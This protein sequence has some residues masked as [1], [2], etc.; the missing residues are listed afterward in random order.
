MGGERHV[1]D[2]LSARE[3][4]GRL[5]PGFL[6]GSGEQVGPLLQRL[7][8]ERVH[9]EVGLRQGTFEEGRIDGEVG[10]RLAHAEKERELQPRDD[11]G[12]FAEVHA[13]LRLQRRHLRP[14][15][16][17]LGDRARFQAALVESTGALG[18][19]RKLAGQ[20]ELRLL[21]RRI[22][23]G[24]AHLQREGAERVVARTP[25][26]THRGPGNVGAQPGQCHRPR[27]RRATG[28]GA[29]VVVERPSYRGAELRIGDRGG[30][31]R[32]AFGGGD[33]RVS[34][35]QVE[36]A[37]A[38]DPQRVIDGDHRGQRGHGESCEDMH[39]VI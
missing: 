39:A 2:A 35:E 30:G 23:D 20:A 10:R 33:L 38:K 5:G 13:L 32:V 16:L 37:L 8:R 3:R 15:Q 12:L 19:L 21:Q 34:D 1:R 14:R 9:G 26:R 29:G 31:G 27:S 24:L 17:R 7:A 4:E 6:R 25:C 28:T 18:R 11:Q 36:A 22:E